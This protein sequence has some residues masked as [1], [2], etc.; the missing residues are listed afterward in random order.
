MMLTKR[1]EPEVVPDDVYPARLEQMIDMPNGQF[2]PALRWVFT[3]TKGEFEGQTVSG[4]TQADWVP[5]QKLDKWMTALGVSPE[6]ATDDE[7]DTEDLIGRKCRIVVEVKMSGKGKNQAERANV[8]NVLPSKKADAS[9]KHAKVG[10][11][12]KHSARG[13]AF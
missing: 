1:A 7:Y 2:G 5:G 4:L 9:T 11:E 3:I 8:K 12:K 10:K 13:D 6:L